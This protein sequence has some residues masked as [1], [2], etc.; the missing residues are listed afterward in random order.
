[1]FVIDVFQ[2]LNERFKDI[3]TSKNNPKFIASTFVYFV[4]TFENCL[5]FV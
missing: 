2:L 3:V 1:M 5:L 4:E